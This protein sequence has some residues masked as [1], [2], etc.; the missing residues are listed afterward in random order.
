MSSSE[1]LPY[2]WSFIYASKHDPNWQLYITKLKLLIENNKS[3]SDKKRQRAKNT[4]RQLPLECIVEILQYVDAT[5]LCHCASVSK[6]WF[7]LSS[8]EKLWNSLLIKQFSISSQHFQSKISN[9]N[10]F[11]SSKELFKISF[12]KL[13]ELLAF[14]C[15]QFKGMNSFY[16]PRTTFQLVSSLSR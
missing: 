7:L 16:I 6:L 15:Q 12:E 14:S 11:I 9:A 3:K 5:T 13:K 8:D 10:D 1:V 4:N 2:C